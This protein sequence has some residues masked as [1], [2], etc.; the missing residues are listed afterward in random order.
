MKKFIQSI[1]LAVALTLF[2]P[3]CAEHFTP[4]YGVT[5]VIEYTEEGLPGRTWKPVDGTIKVNVDT[6][7]VTFIDSETG[8]EVS[9]DSSYR[10]V[11]W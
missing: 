7:V 8:K 5:S 11:S 10:F 4:K 3:G 2:V 1:V 6:D 9:L